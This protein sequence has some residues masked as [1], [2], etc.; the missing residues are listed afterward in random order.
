MSKQSS[1]H[2]INHSRWAE[3]TVCVPL[4]IFVSGHLSQVRPRHVFI[5]M[6]AQATVIILGYSAELVDFFSLKMFLF[7]ISSIIYILLMSCVYVVLVK[8]G[9][10]RDMMKKQWAEQDMALDQ[11]TIKILGLCITFLWLSFP[12]TFFLNLVGVF[13][14]RDYFLSGPFFDVASKGCF[15]GIL[16]TLHFN[17]ELKQKDLI[18]QRGEYKDHMQTKLLRFVYHEVL[19]PL[20][21]IMLALDHLE[22]EVEL[23]QHTPMISMLRKAAAAMFH[24]IDDIVELAQHQGG[25]KLN[26]GPMDIKGVVESALGCFK[27]AAEIKNLKIDCSVDN[28]LPNAVVGDAEKLEKIF[29]TLISNAIKFSPPR[30]EVD[31]MLKLENYFTPELCTVIFSV[32]DSGPGIPDD[33]LKSLFDP[34]GL[35]RPGDFSE[36]EER[37]SGLSLCMLKHLADLLHAEVKFTSIQDQGT[38]FTIVLHCEVCHSFHRKNQWSSHSNPSVQSAFN[39][40]VKKLRMSTKYSSHQPRKMSQKVRPDCSHRYFKKEQAQLSSDEEK[41]SL[42][43]GEIS[44]GARGFQSRAKPEPA[45]LAGNYSQAARESC[46]PCTLL[47]GDLVQTFPAHANQYSDENMTSESDRSCSLARFSDRFKNSVEMQ[48]AT[49][50][51]AEAV[52]HDPEILVVDDIQSNA[53]LAAMIFSK[54]GYLC[55]IAYNGQEAVE[56]ASQYNY[57]LILMDNVMPVMNGIQATRQIL[58]QKNVPIVGITGNILQQDQ[59]IFLQAGAVC[60]IQKP[61]G[62]TTLLHLC[63]VYCQ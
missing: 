51:T 23:E 26:Q 33:T 45:S 54:A 43:F 14:E 12:A 29:S 11:K 27:E 24:V 22:G 13:S 18:I 9:Y 47:S 25:L 15:L 5:A 55:D 31:V 32:K 34:F 8:L 63:N 46:S 4:L 56:L 1:G 19:N 37:G 50:I 60:V 38:T 40:S 17:I 61:A 53:K 28:N 3:W 30:A 59:D 36:D 58:A 49:G 39:K 7:C 57:K 48:D 44:M 52:K 35:V 62:K 21:S 16:N 2:F 42:V 6:S 41:E 10:F 20:N